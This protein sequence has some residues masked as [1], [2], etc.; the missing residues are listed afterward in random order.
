MSLKQQIFEADDIDAEL[1]EV[2][3]WGVVLELRT[4]SGAERAQLMKR[5]SRTDADGTKV[6]IDWEGMY[7]SLIIMT[8]YDPDTGER[9]FE[10]GDLDRLN[11]KSGALLERVAKV[12][13]KL[14][15]MDKEAVEAG[16]DGSSETPA[17]GTGTDSPSASD[18]PSTS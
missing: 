18:E 14:A 5:F 10:W 11:T 1:V 17:N 15:G 12:S 3:E 2:P 13:M 4:P 16:K 9:V 6:E 8:A 7:P